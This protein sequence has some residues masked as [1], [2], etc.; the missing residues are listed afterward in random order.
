MGAPLVPRDVC[1]AFIWTTNEKQRT[2]GPVNLHLRPEIYTSQQ[3]I[4]IKD[5]DKS[6][7]KCRGL[8]DKLFCKNK[9]QIYISAIG[10]EK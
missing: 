10:L 3:P 7:T 8:L 6:Q 5:K 4:K 9:I 1:L 2:S